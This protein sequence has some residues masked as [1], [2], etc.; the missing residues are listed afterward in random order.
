[1]ADNKTFADGFREGYR[2]VMGNGAAL[3]GIPG[4]AIP[5]GKTAYQHGIAKGVEAAIK[6]QASR[7]SED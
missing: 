5:A 2:S 3:P 1:M 4:Y 6:R 7:K